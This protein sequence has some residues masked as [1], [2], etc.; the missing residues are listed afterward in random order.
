MTS[1]CS[2][3]VPVE[4]V[5]K[6]QR[7]RWFYLFGAGLFGT[8]IAEMRLMYN[9]VVP[10][11]R[12]S[13]YLA[14]RYALVGIIAGCMPLAAGQSVSLFEGLKGSVFG[15]PLTAYTP[16]FGIVAVAWI[17]AAFLLGGI[18]EKPEK[19]DDSR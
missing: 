11:E 4:P 3:S 17:A 12:K 13:E 9:T 6:K 14:I 8:R 19:G 15:L 5:E 18:R 16:L 1:E 7:L 2:E 10:E